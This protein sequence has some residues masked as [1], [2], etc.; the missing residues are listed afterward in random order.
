MRTP[1]RF[2]E[3]YNQ[4]KGMN[5]VPG[6]YE[7]T[8]DHKIYIGGIPPTMDEQMVRKICDSFGM[9]R[10]FNLVRDPGDPHKHKGF[11]FIEYVD[12]KVT[13]RAI[14]GLNGL[15]FG[16]KTLK[17]QRSSVGQKPQQPKAPT[18]VN[19]GFL[20]NVPKDKK[21]PIPAFAMTPSRVVQFINILTPEDLIEDEDFESIRE[22]I[23]NACNA[24]GETLEIKI[25]RPDP[26]TGEASAAVGK[27]FVKFS[28]VVAAKQ[29]R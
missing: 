3:E 16:E 29:A 28:H 1:Q 10:S 13:D 5:L 17:A 22:D 8:A 25:P 12:E 6:S 23:L 14:K 20:N 21:I 15:E 18:A 26:H 11:A 2:C 24:F 27:V 4:T 7:S 19:N 9:L